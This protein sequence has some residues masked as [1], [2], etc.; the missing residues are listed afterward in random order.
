M[1]AAVIVLVLVCGYNYIDNHLPSR[2]KL[3][4]SVGWN[5][6]FFVALKGGE[7]LMQGLIASIVV[8]IGLYI[9]MHILNLP[10]YLFGWYEPFT[11][12][13]SI[14]NIRVSGMSFWTILWL[15]L[16]VLI[17]IGKT[18]DVKKRNQSPQKRMEDFREVAKVYAIE[19]LLLESFE[20][21]D[22]GLLVFVTLK[23]RK[24][25]VGMVDGIRFEGMDINTLVLIPFMSGYREKDTLTFHVEHNYTDHYAQQGINFSSE[26]LSVF[27]FRHVLPYEQIESFSLFNVNTYNVFQEVAKEKEIKKKS[28][29]DSN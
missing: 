15:S 4:N 18:A 12:V 17:S 2:Y 26:P 23:S 29:T 20:R 1:W 16:T 5:A 22:D 9:I 14:F 21:M 19:S 6:Y 13:D 10:S 25:Y 11:F 27:Q 28:E 24:V 8:A 3:N 7:F